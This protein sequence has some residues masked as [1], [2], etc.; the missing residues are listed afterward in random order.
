MKSNFLIKGCLIYLCIVLTIQL[1]MISVSIR[2]Q[3]NDSMQQIADE[4]GCQLGNQERCDEVM[5]R[6]EVNVPKPKN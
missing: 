2:D 1:Y 5:R 3:I 6:I 4:I